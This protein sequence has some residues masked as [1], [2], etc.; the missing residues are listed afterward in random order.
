MPDGRRQYQTG[1]E[2]GFRRRVDKALESARRVLDTTREPVLA[3]DVPHEY[4]DKYLLAEFVTN[5]CLA[6]S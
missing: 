5:T 2:S 3:A 1:D 4:A 6:A